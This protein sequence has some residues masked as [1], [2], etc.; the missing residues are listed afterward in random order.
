MT[1]ES[2]FLRKASIADQVFPEISQLVLASGYRLGTTIRLSI[3]VA[4]LL[5]ALAIYFVPT[6]YTASASIRVRQREG[7]L[8]TT[9]ESRSEDAAFVRA[10]ESLV[11]HNETLRR[12]LH[13]ND[14]QSYVSTG[15]ER[16][17]IEYLRSQMKA[18]IPSGSEIMTITC[19]SPSPA[20]SVLAAD[21]VSRSYI[22]MITDQINSARQRR[23]AELEIAAKQADEQLQ[24]QWRLLQSQ[25]E[26]LG[27][28]NP[29]TL[30]LNEQIRIQSF[31][32]AS[33]RLRSLDLQKAMVEI[34]IA[35]ERQKET[36]AGE[37][38]EAIFENEVSQHPDLISRREQ[39][40]LIDQK[41]RETRAIVQRE[42]TPRLVRLQKDREH[43][44]HELADVESAVL[45]AVRVQMMPSDHASTAVSDLKSREE[46]LKLIQQ[47]MAFLHDSMNGLESSIEMAGGTNGVELEMIRHEIDRE[48]K[49][50]D[51]L[52]QILQ[53][54]RIEER[55]EPRVSLISSPTAP[56]GRSR[57]RQLKAVAAAG[58]LGVIIAV[59]GIGYTEWKSCLIR[60]TTHIEQNV[61]IPLFGTAVF[62]SFMFSKLFSFGRRYRWADGANELVA[63]LLL[64]PNDDGSI[65][66]LT[67]TSATEAESSER[68]AKRVAQLLVRDG[69]R[70]LLVDADPDRKTYLY[71]PDIN[72]N[73]TFVKP[74]EKLLDGNHVI[75]SSE[76][77]DFEYLPLKQS[78]S[79]VGNAVPTG[80]T[81][82]FTEIK[83]RYQAIIVLGPAVL[84]NA[85]TVLLAAQTDLTVLSI[86]AGISRWDLLKAACSR[87]RLANVTLLGATLADCVPHCER[88]TNMPKV[89]ISNTRSKPVAN[90]DEETLYRE[91]S[92]IQSHLDH[93]KV[94]APYS[95]MP[96]EPFSRQ[97]KHGR[98]Y[99][100][101]DE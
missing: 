66:S 85:E 83:K 29:Q 41:I 12:A 73:A 48:A 89:M 24:R 46:Q 96:H 51:R 60:H 70:V 8:L 92:E 26:K 90:V 27:A 10:Q 31:R 50:N 63:Q 97:K 65:K 38:I 32:E 86:T 36:P 42:D 76:D 30:S 59:L 67:V 52:W 9:Q 47:E 78:P 15:S 3:V 17:Q 93:I 40:R 82:I 49:L 64:K 99:K 25:A 61:G 58:L 57:S 87:L 95:S 35:H 21:V 69:R 71:K 75:W 19:S 33:Q 2:N 100:W 18:D 4:S 39:L 7:V 81:T 6:Q 28:G 23:I 72:E 22:E 53:E 45:K 43:Y 80:L 68:L 56:D 55:A 74:C 5:V 62:G 94:E 84:F 91:T 20:L 44:A 1:A 79:S 37:S 54:L 14:L 101:N 16:E 98:V 11:I 13:D 77:F 34:E 88:H